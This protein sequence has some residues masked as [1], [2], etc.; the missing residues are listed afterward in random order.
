VPLDLDL[1][2]L[3]HFAAVAETGALTRAAEQLHIA[4]AVLTRQVR[5]LETELHATLPLF[6]EGRVVAR[7]AGIRLL[8]GLTSR[9]PHWLISS[10]D[11]HPAALDSL[12]T[13]LG[14]NSD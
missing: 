14:L 3:R 12:A 2:T 13:A 6:S 1:R 8:H 11:D 5:A 9:W 7:P 10:V 4:Q